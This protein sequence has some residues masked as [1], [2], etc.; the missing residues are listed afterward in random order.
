ME[1]T[2]QTESADGYTMVG[3]ARPECRWTE[4]NT[5]IHVNFLEA[6]SDYDVES[7]QPLKESNDNDGSNNMKENPNEVFYDC[8][9]G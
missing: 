3:S 9:S 6:P 5:W 4:P 1:T 2:T 7:L 8:C